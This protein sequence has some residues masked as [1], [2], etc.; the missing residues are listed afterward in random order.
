[1]L[2]QQRVNLSVKFVG[3]H[4]HTWVERS[5]V[6]VKSLAQEHN[7]M[8]LAETQTQTTWSGDKSTDDETITPPL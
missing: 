6:R 7:A 1:M 8:S 2:V 3:T 4:L 5:T